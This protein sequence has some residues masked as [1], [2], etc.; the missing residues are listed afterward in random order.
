MI[1]W[2]N[3]FIERIKIVLKIYK[4]LNI[5]WKYRVVVKNINTVL[6]IRA[7][8]IGLFI[9][10]GFLVLSFSETKSKKTKIQPGI[11]ISFDD[12]YVDEWTNADLILQKYKWKATF[13]VTKFNQL[14]KL[15]IGK[16]KVLKKAGHE[17]GG[18]GLNHLNAIIYKT[19]Y[20]S[21]NYL[22]TEINPMLN[23]MK[24]NDL[25][26]TSFAYPFGFR[27]SLTDNKLFNIFKIIRG[28]TYCKVPP[29]SQNC[30]YTYNK[31]VFG[32]GIDKN[33][34]HSSIP[35]FLSLL[36]YAKKNNKI[37]IFYAHKPVNISHKNKEIEYK[38][39]IALCKYVQTNNMKFYKMSELASLKKPI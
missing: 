28:T 24:I 17:I 33:Y 36:E 14:S 5:N 1:L 38:T 22:K 7:F 32:L 37:V 18:H 8:F 21:S 3:V 30:Y 35:Y 25:A 15:K 29:S 11:V 27:T 9:F 6:I 23:V 4:V 26:P 13:F 34:P 16:L 31:L 10:F 19:K 20:G 12:D 39:L 2:V